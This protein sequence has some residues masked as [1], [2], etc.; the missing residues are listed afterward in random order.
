MVERDGQRVES[1]VTPVVADRPVLD[2]SGAPVLG[3]DG[4]PQTRSVG[5]LGIGPTQG[6]QPES[7]TVVPGMLADRLAQTA[8]VIVTLP[9]R[10]VDIAQVALGLEERDPTSVVGPVGVGRFAGEIASAQI[11]G[12]DT[13]LRTA[14]LL[15]MVAG[16]NIA[17]FAFNLVP[18]LPLD[19]GHVV[20]ALYEGARRQVAKVRGRPRPAPADTARMMPLA[21][22]VFVVMAAMGAIIAYVDI[23][24]PVQ[25]M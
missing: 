13:A 7:V 5:F 17:L 11:D 10:M 15:M 20:G 19:G 18:L 2:E 14:D 3:S 1:V 24:R 12:Y 9:A 21:Y 23:V 16:L 8:Q 22:G 25:L 6:L 4:E